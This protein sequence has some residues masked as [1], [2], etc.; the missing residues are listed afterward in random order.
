MPSFRWTMRPRIV[1]GSIVSQAWHE[2]SN[3]GSELK[4]T[5]ERTSHGAFESGRQSGRSFHRNG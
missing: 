2:C 4:E 5:C 1:A 3:V